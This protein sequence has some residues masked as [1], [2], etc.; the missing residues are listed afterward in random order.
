MEKPPESKKTKSSGGFR[1]VRRLAVFF[2]GGILVPVVTLFASKAWCPQVA[3]ERLLEEATKVAERFRTLVLAA[4]CGETPVD[5]G[6]LLDLESKLHRDVAQECLDPLVGAIIQ[7]AHDHPDV[8]RRVREL[9][10]ATPFLK[11]QN[12][13]K[14]VILTLLGGSQVEVRTDYFL[15]RSG[16]R[17]GPKRKVGQRGKAGNGVYPTLVVLGIHHR[18]SPALA[19]EVARLLVRMPYRDAQDSLRR[20]GVELDLKTVQALAL[21]LGQLGLSFRDWCF[22]QLRSGECVLPSG[23]VKGKRIVITWDGGR[24]RTREKKKR[25]RR[26]KSGRRGFLAPWREPRVLVIYELDEEGRKKKEG[27]VIYDAT[28][29]RADAFLELLTD[30]LRALGAQEA[31]EWIVI[32]DGADWIWERVPRLV[33]AL[34]YDSSQVTE[35]VDFYHAVEHLTEI[36]RTVKSWTDEQ[37]KQWVKRM[38]RLLKAGKV[39]RILE[40]RHELCKGRN[41]KTVRKAFGYFETHQHRMRYGQFA[42]RKL[43]LGS[44]AVESCVRRLINLRMKGNGIFWDPANAEVIMHMRAQLL[45]GTWDTFVRAA[46][47]PEALRD[48]TNPVMTGLR[49]PA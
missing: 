13:A 25:G 37:R 18:V 21:K 35:I 30:H 15:R 16:R 22:Q 17:G 32:A 10:L 24:I 11:P 28:M 48:R 19:S 39:D 20:R 3:R 44:G 36:S 43:P 12:R 47:E 42:A 7:V 14:K 29:R 40:E 9:V 4:V 6:A 1:R 31:S 26:R 41:A 46:L 2:S 38:R 33:E 27:L 23:R 49:R 34:G 8:V 5:P 45:S